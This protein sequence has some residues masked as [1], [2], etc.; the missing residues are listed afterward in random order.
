M[1]TLVLQQS[2]RDSEEKWKRLSRQVTDIVLPQLAALNVSAD[3]KI[4]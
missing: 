3:N 1:L 2:R 4:N